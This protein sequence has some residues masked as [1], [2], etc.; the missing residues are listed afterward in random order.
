MQKATSKNST[1]IS[2]DQTGERQVTHSITKLTRAFLIC[3][4]IAGP[5]YPGA[6][7]LARLSIRGWDA[8]GLKCWSGSDLGADTSRRLRCRTDRRWLLHC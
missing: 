6:D 7:R 5:F 3:G 2:F 1:I 4:L 8:A